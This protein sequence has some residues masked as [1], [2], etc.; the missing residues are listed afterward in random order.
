LHSQSKW[1][2]IVRS[3]DARLIQRFCA[4]VAGQHRRRQ[5]PRLMGVCNQTDERASSSKFDRFEQ[6]LVA[7]S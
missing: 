3:G 6:F 2:A 5:A 7:P 1:Q 4:L